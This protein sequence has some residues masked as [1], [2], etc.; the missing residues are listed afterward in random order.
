MIDVT[1]NRHEGIGGSE[2]AAAIGLS[3]YKT[4][5]QVYFDKIN[6][7]HSKETTVQMELGNYLEPFLIQKYEDLS[8]NKC[9]KPQERLSNKDYPWLMAHIDGWVKD[10]NLIFE[11][12]TTRF[13]NED[14]GDDGTDFIPQEYLIQVAHYCIVCDAYKTVDWAEILAL[15]RSD[16]VLRRYYYKRNAELEKL[17]IEKT[18]EFWENNVLQMTPPEPKN[19]DDIKKLYNTATQNSH[20]IATNEISSKYF[21]LLEIRKQMKEL[22]NNKEQIENDLKCFMRDSESLIDI[23][24]D[25]LSTWKN[26]S[27]N[28]LDTKKL[29]NDLP[30]IY[31]KYTISSNSRVFLCK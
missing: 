22:E 5:L 15:S 23:N 13:F 24:G 21:E 29:K 20:V 12:K 26:R 28:R 1:V 4:P 3:R 16:S 18:K 6:K 10:T 31:E 27:A 9:E 11:A 7:D 19:F 30:S 2:C 8:G 17:I 25:L 14:W